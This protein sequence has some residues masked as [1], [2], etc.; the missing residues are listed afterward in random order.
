MTNFVIFHGDVRHEKSPDVRHEKSPGLEPFSPKF[1]SDR[2]DSVER[3]IRE[4]ESRQI[5][6]AQMNVHEFDPVIQ[7]YQELKNLPD[8]AEPV[9]TRQLSLAKKI[10]NDTEKDS[11][12]K[13]QAF[14]SLQNMEWEALEAANS[15][16]C[17]ALIDAGKFPQEALKRVQIAAEQHQQKMLTLTSSQRTLDQDQTRELG[18]IMA[19][20]RKLTPHVDSM[21]EGENESAIGNFSQT[22]TWICD[23]HT[24]GHDITGGKIQPKETGEKNQTK[25][26]K[27][28]TKG[29]R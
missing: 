4:G 9:I 20:I 10:A 3:Q 16:L 6:L 12:S 19:T 29:N 2:I 17:G 13:V 11:V 27:K 24:D 18:D 5:S 26:M 7:I 22:A 15:Q 21:E 1:V 25:E 23:D 8:L 28:P 14:Q